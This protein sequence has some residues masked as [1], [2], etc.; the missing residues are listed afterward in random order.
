MINLNID[1]DFSQSQMPVISIKKYD[2][3]VRFMSNQY[4]LKF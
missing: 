4:W 1:K 2:S 3:M